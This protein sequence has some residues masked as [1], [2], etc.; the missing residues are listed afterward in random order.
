MMLDLEEREW[1][2]AT[3]GQLIGVTRQATA[4]MEQRGVIN[5]KAQTLH[6]ALL[7]YLSH[8]RSAAAGRAGSLVDERA[9]LAAEQADRVAM[10]NA[11][12]RRELAPMPVITETIAKAAKGICD[13][14]DA[15]PADI[16]RRAGDV[17]ERVVDI[18][19]ESIADARRQVATLE[20]DWAHADPESE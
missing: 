6:E 9:R 11:Q 5:R 7:A 13:K 20:I 1:T 15:I 10:Q 18:V 17:P 4:D 3:F 14:L 8:L 19:T 16:K 2:Q 12:M